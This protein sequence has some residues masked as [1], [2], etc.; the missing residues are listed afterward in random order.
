MIDIKSLLLAF[1]PVKRDDCFL[2]AASGGM[3][4][5]V[6]C[7]LCHR[8]GLQIELAHCNFGLREAESER[9]EQ[10][11]KS[12]AAQ[13]KIPFHSKKFNTV[14]FAEEKKISIQEAARML[15][16][17]WFEQLLIT[18]S[19]LKWVLTAHH[20]EDDAETIAMN[21]FRGTGLKGLMGIPAISGN[22]L[23]P[24][25]SV[26]QQ[27]LR[28]YATDHGINFVTD[29]S[30]L[31]EDYTRNYFRHTII[32]AVEKVFPSTTSNLIEN[33]LR[34]QQSNE[35]MQYFMDQ[36]RQKYLLKEGEEYQLSIAQL[37]KFEK[38][39][40]LYEIL[41]PF[42]FSAGQT[43]EAALLLHARTGA[44]LEAVGGEWRL[45]RNRKML[46]LSPSLSKHYNY[47]SIMQSDRELNFADGIL[48]MDQLKKENY[49]VGNEELAC[50]DLRKLEFPLTLR[51]WK[52]G[53]YFYPLGMPK[54]KKIS[55]FLIDLKLSLTQKEKVWVLTSGDKICWVV[56]HRIDDRFKLTSMSETVFQLKKHP[57]YCK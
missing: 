53:D 40:L 54:K 52:E 2:V 36:F 7:D 10:F 6:L 57:P 5:T 18:Q 12:F 14:A 48:L 15:R 3:D 16:Y 17:D 46:I 23:R 30:N 49:K 28:T 38:T 45:I 4:S 11:V 51:K 41:S 47:Y 1:G 20:Q 22:I 43:K 33:K 13:R 19:H 24:L 29:S 8:V 50:L 35:L 39:S 32:P 44:Q 21:F 42:G 31:K 26:S 34:V 9:D 37:V 25:L 55:R 56:G 27:E